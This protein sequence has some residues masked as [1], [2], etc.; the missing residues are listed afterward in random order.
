MP[1][2]LDL[3][4]VNGAWHSPEVWEPVT[5]ALEEKHYSSIVPL[6]DFVNTKDP[7]KSIASSVT[8]LQHIIADRTSKGCDVVLVTHSFGGA[9][10]CSAVK[11]FTAK[12]SSRLSGAAGKLLGIVQ[13][14]AFMP[15]ANTS[16]HDI[17]SRS[18]KE[19]FH[20]SDADGWEVIDN[21]DPV[22]IFYNDLPP[23][24]AQH[25]KDKLRKQPS[26]AF[27]DRENIYP[28][29]ADVPVWYLLCKQD[30]AIPI[31]AQEAMVAAAREAGATVVT[32]TLDCSHSPLLSRVDETVAF[33]ERA[34]DDFLYSSPPFQ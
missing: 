18:P 11:G 2:N 20:H 9:V 10:G 21:G 19:P 8:Q 13:L 17:I 24:V 32:E 34:V 7:L 22:D 4:F 3:I 29:W 6:L 5:Y 25:W 23:D 14:C 16:L 33:I 30:H 15:P 28:G 31:Q 1:S 26:G 12:D 27:K